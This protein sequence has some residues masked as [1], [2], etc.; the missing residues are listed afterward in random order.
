M[1]HLASPGLTWPRHLAVSHPSVDHLLMLLLHS[2]PAC[3]RRSGSLPPRVT[4]HDPA[5]AHNRAPAPAQPQPITE[6][7]FHHNLVMSTN[8]ST[9][10]AAAWPI[11]NVRAG[12]W[13]YLYTNCWLLQTGPMSTCRP[14]RHHLPLLSPPG[15]WRPPW[16]H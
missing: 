15:C 7:G 11:N 2:S 9:N 13:G 6:L 12:D 8:T 5:P 1:L 16:P 14:P 4:F 3:C 10:T